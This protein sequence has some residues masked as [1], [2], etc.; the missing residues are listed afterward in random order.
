MGGGW[1]VG[2]DGA[3][4]LQQGHMTQLRAGPGVEGVADAQRLQQRQ[5]AGR[6]AFAADFAARE[7][8][9]LDQRDGPAGAGQLNRR[10]RAGQ[11][12]A[13]DERVKG[14]ARRGRHASAPVR[15]ALKV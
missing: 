11:P 13:H 9:A 4:A 12:S 1:Q 14:G 15:Q 8:L 2:R 6:D 10:R 7:A 5:I 3:V